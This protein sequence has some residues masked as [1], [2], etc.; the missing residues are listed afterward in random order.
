MQKHIEV[1]TS[2]TAQLAELSD[3]LQEIKSALE[4]E[5]ERVSSFV[6]RDGD[7]IVMVGAQSANPRIDGVCVP[8]APKV[9]EVDPPL[10]D[11]SLDLTAPVTMDD[12]VAVADTGESATPAPEE[13]AG[14]AGERPDDLL[15]PLLDFNL[16]RSISLAD[17][18]FYANELFFGNKIR[19]EELL[20]EIEHFSGMSQVE[21]YLY[22]V[23]GFSRDDA[24]V[25]RLVG[26][27]IANATVRK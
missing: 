9:A 8:D 1:L 24:A 11:L 26:F 25:R 21:H 4:D 6:T 10:K 17:T 5:L 7:D 12:F 27:I 16:V 18:F 22:E 3:R 14:T 23:C 19:L 20:S 15:E 2:L 13:G